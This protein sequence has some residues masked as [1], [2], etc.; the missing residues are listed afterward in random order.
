M[1]RNNDKIEGD[2]IRGTNVKEEIRKD[3]EDV[4]TLLSSIP[5]RGDGVDIMAGVREKLRH[6]YK[7]AKIDELVEAEAKEAETVASVK[8]EAKNG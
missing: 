8:K 2:Y 1:E 6:A 3:L 5:V 7:L 4:F